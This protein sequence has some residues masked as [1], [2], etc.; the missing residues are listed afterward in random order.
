LRDLLR[1]L[2]SPSIK[3]E[4]WTEAGRFEKEIF[5]VSA[6]TVGRTGFGQVLRSTLLEYLRYAT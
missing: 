3:A 6:T 4:I 1:D 5:P 2:R